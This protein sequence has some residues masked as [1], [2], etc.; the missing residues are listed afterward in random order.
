MIYLL[1]EDVDASGYFFARCLLFCLKKLYIL[2][3]TRD[4]VGDN[5]PCGRNVVPNLCNQARLKSDINTGIYPLLTKKSATDYYPP[6]S[7]ISLMV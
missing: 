5:I 3:L 1:G 2:Q 4:E 7:L 6:R